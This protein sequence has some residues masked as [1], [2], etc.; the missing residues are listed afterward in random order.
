MGQADRVGFEPFCAPSQVGQAAVG[1]RRPCP[2][3]AC[4]S[5][6]HQRQRAWSPARAEPR[7]RPASASSSQLERLQVAFLLQARWRSHASQPGRQHQQVGGLPRFCATR[8]RTRGRSRRHG[9]V[10][11][12]MAELTEKGCRQL[13]SEALGRGQRRCYC[14]GS[15]QPRH[16]GKTCGADG[17]RGLAI[18]SCGER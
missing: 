8:Q 6:P 16:G 1:S 17:R 9:R 13:L 4:S 14:R 2:G 12:D 7:W 18:R 5:K 3:A 11:G 10:Q 15:A